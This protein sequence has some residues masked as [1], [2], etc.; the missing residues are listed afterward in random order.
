VGD[1]VLEMYRM[2][3]VKLVDRNDL[4]VEDLESLRNDRGA[5]PTMS[6][7][8]VSAR[9]VKSRKGVLPVILGRSSLLGGLGPARL[10]RTSEAI[11]VS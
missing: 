10:A 1:W 8:T 11:N 7:L 3:W 9:P 2:V 5:V 4:A 6:V